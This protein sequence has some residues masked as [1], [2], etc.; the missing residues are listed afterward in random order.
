MSEIN[1][2]P[3]ANGTL[4]RNTDNSVVFVK[5]GINYV[6]N[7]DEM[8]QMRWIIEGVLDGSLEQIVMN[9]KNIIKGDW[10]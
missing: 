3:K 9:R 4:F 6:L 8:T 1:L 10:F 2:I 5:N 7:K